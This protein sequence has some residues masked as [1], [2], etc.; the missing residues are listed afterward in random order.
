MVGKDQILLSCLSVEELSNLIRTTMKEELQNLLPIEDN[1]ISAS[2]ACKIFKPAITKNTLKSWVNQGLIN[3]VRYNSRVYYR[4]S[5]I[6]KGSKE[7][8]K[9]KTSYAKTMNILND[10]SI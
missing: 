5:E 8:K 1:L 9:Y 2:E 10:F 3:E 6:I 7:I 4:K